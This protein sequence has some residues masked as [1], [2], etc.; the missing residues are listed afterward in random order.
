MD[1][2]RQ[3]AADDNFEIE[4]DGG[5]NA[6]TISQCAKAG[7]DIFVAGSYLFNGEAGL[8]KRIDDI[9]SLAVEAKK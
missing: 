8:E 6:D 9:R 7:A 3:T 2:L 1:Q 5:I 4:V